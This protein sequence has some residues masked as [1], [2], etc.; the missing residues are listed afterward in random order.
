MQMLVACT[1]QPEQ[2]M[3][4]ESRSLPPASKCLEADN[5]LGRSRGGGG[6]GTCESEWSAPSVRAL[7]YPESGMRMVQMQIGYEVM[8]PSECETASR[9]AVATEELRMIAFV[10]GS[11]HTL[12]IPSNP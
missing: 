8:V 9:T 1:L 5:E 7:P 6:G 3:G 12:Y 2:Y 10:F 11:E 4:S